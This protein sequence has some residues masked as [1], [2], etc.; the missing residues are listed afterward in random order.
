[1]SRPDQSITFLKDSGYSVLRMP[2]SDAR[3]LQTLRKE[4]KKDLTRLGELATI[5]IA[6]SNP[7]PPLSVDNAAPI[8]ISGKE[9]SSTKI[10]IGVNILGNI[11]Q[12]LGGKTLGISAGF[13]KAKTMTFKFED[14]LEDHADVDRLD[15]YLTTCAFRADM[16]SVTNALIDDEVY[17]VTS[18]IKTN[19]FTINAKGDSGAKIGLDVPA[20]AQVA[21]GSL[22]V[23]TAKATEGTVVYKGAKPVVFGFQAVRLFFDEINGRPT[24]SAMNTLEPGA[25]AARSAGRVKP[26]LLRLDEGAFFRLEVEKEM[27]AVGAGR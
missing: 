19:K 16:T 23:E 9:S 21:S 18:T 5:T 7:L 20:I 11:I 1:M 13:A 10:E 17:V 15:Q 26:T 25:A 6:G 4:G 27:T 14:V 12:A 24:F 8:E 22:S 2:R 3:P